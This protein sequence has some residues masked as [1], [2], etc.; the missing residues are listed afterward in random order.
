MGNPVVHFEIGGR[1]TGKSKDFYA[2]LFN[3]KIEEMGPA[4]MIS[5]ASD[6]GIG[7]HISALGHEPHNYVTV[8]V[9]VENIPATLKKAEELGGSTMVPETEIP[10]MGHFAWLKDVDGNIVGLWKSKSQD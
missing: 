6:T 1:D 2:A 3:W 9:Q 10:D 4:M 7:G 8:Y 5:T